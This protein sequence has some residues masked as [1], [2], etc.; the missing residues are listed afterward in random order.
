MTSIVAPAAAGERPAARA[1]L[2]VLQA[3]TVAYDVGYDLQLRLAA[4]REA[5]RLPDTLLLL[6]HPPTITLGRNADRAHVLATPDEL[7]ARGITRVDTD[8]GGD[9]TYHG[10]GQLVGYPILDL[11]RPPHRPDLH[12]YFRNMEEAIIRTLGEFG[13]KG[14]RYGGHTG[15]WVDRGGNRQEKVA[16]M[17]IRVSRWIT[18]HG[19]A[20]NVCPD[21]AHFGSIVPCGIHDHGVTSMAAVLDRPIS[22]ADVTPIL[23]QSF[24]EVFGLQAVLDADAQ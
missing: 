11:S 14:D 9:V 6:E 21:L 17:G 1:T 19:F 7:A 4:E 24:A 2:R 5:G 3:G 18:R 10:P 20:L 15:V 22:V 13:I 12:L 23:I 16:A 8:R